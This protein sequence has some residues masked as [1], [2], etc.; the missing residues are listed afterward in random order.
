MPH[1]VE[2][3]PATPTLSSADSEA[4]RRKSVMTNVLAAIVAEMK[5]YTIRGSVNGAATASV[6]TRQQA[7][8]LSTSSS[9]R[10]K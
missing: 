2:D 8:L 3:V 7:F 4:A 6:S 5:Q 1:S 10:L 9:G